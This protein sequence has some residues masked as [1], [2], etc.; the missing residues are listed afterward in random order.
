MSVLEQRHI[1]LYCYP[2]RIKKYTYWKTVDLKNREIS[3]F[4]VIPNY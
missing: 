2:Q 1:Q 4:H 3:P